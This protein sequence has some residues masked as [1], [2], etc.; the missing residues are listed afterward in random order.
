MITL[1]IQFTINDQLFL[2]TLL[3]EMRRSTISYAAFR[4]KLNNELENKLCDDIKNL[5]YD[6]NIDFKV[7]DIFLKIN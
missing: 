6:E 2:E 5:E 7:I 4:E 1:E 3:T